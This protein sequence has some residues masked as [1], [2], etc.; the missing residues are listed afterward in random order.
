MQIFASIIQFIG[1]RLDLTLVAFSLI[2][3]PSPLSPFVV[4]KIRLLFLH[5]R[6]G[7]VP[8][9]LFSSFN[10]LAKKTKTKKLSFLQE[11]SSLVNAFQSAFIFCLKKCCWL[12]S[13][14][15]QFSF[16]KKNIYINNLNPKQAFNFVSHQ[17]IFSNRANFYHCPHTVCYGTRHLYQNSD[18]QHYKTMTKEKVGITVQNKILDSTWKSHN[19]QRKREALEASLTTAF[20]ESFLIMRKERWL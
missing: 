20:S 1:L 13:L 14:K 4:K 7:S 17:N 10:V 12:C 15:F 11:L 3:F 16:L 19:Q 9:M 8:V 6:A 2:F 18:K 5:A